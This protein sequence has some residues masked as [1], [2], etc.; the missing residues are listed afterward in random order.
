MN[1]TLWQAIV[2]SELSNC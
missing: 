1:E 2:D